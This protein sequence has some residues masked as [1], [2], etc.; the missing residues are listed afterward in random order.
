M[1]RVVLHIGPMKTGSTA[2]Q[3]AL[4]E[5]H[6][7]LREQGILALRPFNASFLYVVIDRQLK[8]RQPLPLHQQMLARLRQDLAGVKAEDH[9]I[10]LSGELFGQGLDQEGVQALIELLRQ[11]CPRPIERLEAVCYLRRQDEL[12]VSLASTKLRHGL[13]KLPFT[14]KPFNYAAMLN[15]W[16]RALGRQAV[17]PRRY[18]PSS[19]E[20]GDVVAD[21]AAV[22]GVPYSML[23]LSTN[24]IRN[25]SLNPQAQALLECLALA[26]REKPGCENP[27]DLPGWSALIRYLG[28]NY[29][30]LGPQPS[31]AKAESFMAS[32][33][34]ENE[35]VA[36][37][38][39]DDGLPLFSSDYSRYPAEESPKVGDKAVLDAAVA[40]LIQLLQLPPSS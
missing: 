18:D 23:R 31:R 28:S 34:S 10:L 13:I 37:Q 39:F 11:A 35:I 32:I 20:T 2:I 40:S 6:K 24:R 7:A 4:G 36:R 29:S 21:F 12:S 15:V 9:T 5:H 8:Q 27:N 22:L 1:V 38:W 3:A 25:S 17:Q 30:G 33:Q 26:L 19:W 14:G 16:E